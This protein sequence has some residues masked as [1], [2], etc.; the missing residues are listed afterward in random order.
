MV[1]R[2]WAATAFYGSVDTVISLRVT[3]GRRVF[4]AAGRDGVDVEKTLL[5]MSDSG[6][7]TVAGTK[8]ASSIGRTWRCASTN[9]WPTRTSR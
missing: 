6:L 4:Y 7:V 3:E 1:T 9:G 2:C 5:T 8:V